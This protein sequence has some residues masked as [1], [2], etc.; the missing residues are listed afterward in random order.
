MTSLPNHRSSFFARPSI[1]RSRK[2]AAVSLLAV[3]LLPLVGCSKKDEPPPPAASVTTP[4]K[5]TPTPDLPPKPKGF[6]TA[7]GPPLVILPGKGVNAIR[8]GTNLENLQKHMGGPCDIVSETR[9]IYV[10]QAS[11]YHLKDGVVSAMKFYRRGRMVPDVADAKN[12]ATEKHFGL[13]NGGMRPEIMFGLHRHIVE[14]E[15]GKPVE[16][17]KLEGPDGQVELHRYAGVVFEY[18]QLENENVVLSAIEVIPTGS[19]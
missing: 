17:E 8:F 6:G 16:K 2:S 12:T 18:D 7:L 14:E 19:P 1:F 15:F 4:K 3:A 13:F 10:R 9:C 5:S 11:E